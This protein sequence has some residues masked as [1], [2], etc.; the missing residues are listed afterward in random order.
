MSGKAHDE[1]CVVVAT[2]VALFDRE[3][4]SSNKSQQTD[5]LVASPVCARSF[6]QA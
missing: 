6:V 5:Y 4:I 1:E 2:S 3:L